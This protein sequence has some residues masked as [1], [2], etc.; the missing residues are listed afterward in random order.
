MGPQAHWGVGKWGG[1]GWTLVTVIPVPRPSI[2]GMS[3]PNLQEQSGQGQE[4]GEG[5]CIHLSAGFWK[6]GVSECVLGVYT[7]G[8]LGAGRHISWW[9]CG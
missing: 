5:A 6:R 3:S 7:W 4:S 9:G 1:P 2:P 8:S